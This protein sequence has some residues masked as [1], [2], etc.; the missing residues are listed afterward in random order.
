MWSH[1]A[2]QHSGFCIEYDCR[3]GTGLRRLVYPVHYSDDAPSVSAADLMGL[4][5][6]AALDSL[7]LTKA[8]CWS[9]EQEWRVLMAHGGKSYQAPSPIT[10]IIFGAR[11]PESERTM[12]Q[13]AL[14]HSGEIDFKEAVLQEGRFRLELRP[15]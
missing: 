6:S 10:S 15:I 1:Y 5:K 11:M 13:N 2:N 8:T 14:R 12:V 4:E 7:W 3:E 9:Y